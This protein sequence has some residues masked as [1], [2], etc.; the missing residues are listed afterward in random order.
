MTYTCTTCQATKQEDIP[1]TGHSFADT[2]ISNETHHWHSSTC[3][4]IDEIADKGEHVWDDGKITTPA[5]CS[6]AGV[7]TYTCTT[8]QA[9][10]QEDIPNTGH[11]FADTWTSNETHHW[12]SS[13]CEHTDEIADKGEHVWDDGKITTPASCSQAGVMTYTCTTCQAIKQEDIPNTG[14]PFADT[15]TSNETHHWHSSTCEHTEEITDKGEHVWDEGTIITSATFDSDG[16]IRY[17]CSVCGYYYDDSIPAEKHTFSNEWTNDATHHWHSATCEHTDLVSDKGEHTWDEGIVRSQPTCLTNG[18]ITYSCTVCDRKV[19]K[20][21]PATGHSYSDDWSTDSVYHW[22][23]ASCE[24]SNLIL[25]KNEHEWD[26]GKITIEAGC[27]TKGTIIF[28]C[29]TCGCERIEELLEK[30]HVFEDAWTS[31]NTYHWHSATCEHISEI[32]NKGEHTW[33]EGKVTLAPGC[34]SKGIFT[35]SCTVCGKTKAIDIDETGHEYSTNW[36]SDDDY[37]WHSSTCEH[38]D[39]I[40]DKSDHTWDEG[41]V[42][43]PPTCTTEGISTYTCTVCDK[44]KNTTINATG[45]TLSEKTVA[46]TCSSDGYVEVY[47]SVCD[48]SQITEVIYSTGHDCGDWSTTVASSCTQEGT[49]HRTC[50]DCD[51]EEFR[52]LAKTAHDYVVIDISIVDS[53][54]ETTYQCAVC[55]QQ[56]VQNADVSSVYNDIILD[57]ETDFYFDIVFDGTK[58]EIYSSLMIFDAYFEDTEYEFSSSAKVNYTITLVEGNVWRIAP[59]VNYEQGITYIARITND[60]IKFK[61]YLGDT[62]LFSIKSEIHEKIE[63]SND[64]IFLKEL[65]NQAPGYYPYALYYHEESE[66]LYLTVGKVDGLT[67]GSILCVGEIENIEGLFT[68]TTADVYFGKIEKISADSEGQYVVIMS[69]P[70]MSELFDE[71]DVYIEQNIDF[72]NSQLEGDIEEQ[73]EAAL[74][75]NSDFLG[76][77]SSVNLTAETYL[78]ERNLDTT[79]LTTASFMDC[80]NLDPSVRVDGTKIYVTINGDITIPVKTKSGIEIGSIKVYFKANT[81]IQ[82]EVSLNH[83]IKYKWFIPTGVEY[84]DFRLTQ[85]DTFTFEFGVDFTIDYNAEEMQTDYIYN[86]NSKMLHSAECRH[87]RNLIGQSNNLK[88]ITVDQLIEYLKQS[89]TQICDVCK[90]GTLNKEILMVNESSKKVHCFNCFMVT[91]NMV[92]TNQT[93]EALL[94]A[95]YTGCDICNPDSTDEQDFESRLLQTIEYADWSAK[96]QEITTWAKDSNVSEY[97]ATGVKLCGVNF[98]VAYVFTVNLDVSMV[99]QFKLEASLAYK[100]E[101]SHSNT[102][103]MRLQNGRVDTY[104]VKSQNTNTNELHVVGKAEFKYGIKADVYVS[105]IG[106]S[107][108]VR[109][110]MSAEAGVY[111]EIAGV[112]HIS[113]ID[114]DDYAAAYLEAGLYFEIDAYYKLFKWQGSTE[115]YSAKLALLAYGYDR[116]YYGYTDYIESVNI[117]DECNISSLVSLKANYY[118]LQTMDTA[119]EVLSLL[120]VDGKYNVELWLESGTYLEIV[121]GKLC[122]KNNHPCKFTDVLHI[123]VT[124]DNTWTKYVKGNAAYYLEDYVVTINYYNE[125]YHNF[126]M[127]SHTDPTCVL[128]GNTQYHCSVCDKEKIDV[129]SA[130]GVHPWDN[131]VVTQELTCTQDGY[132]LYSCTTCSLTR[133]ETKAATGHYYSG[134]YRFDKENHWHICDNCELESTITDKGSHTFDE[135]NIC[136][137]CGTTLAVTEG[138]KYTLIND[139]TAYEVSVGDAVDAKIVIPSEYEG[140]PVIAIAQEGFA[141]CTT[142]NAIVIPNTIKSVGYQAFMECENLVDIY[143]MGTVKD[144]CDIVFEKYTTDSYISTSFVTNP[145]AFAHNLYFGNKLAT[146]IVIPDSVTQLGATA[147]I[148][149][150][151]SSLNIIVIPESVTTIEHNALS[152]DKKD[153]VLLC[154]AESEPSGWDYWWNNYDIPVV[155]NYGGTH[156]VNND[157][158]WAT[159][160][161]N[162]VVIA[163][164]IGHNT[165]VRIPSTINSKKVVGIAE[166]AFYEI[167]SSEIFIVPNTIT[168]VGSNAFNSKHLVFA[169]AKSA[170]ENWHWSSNRIVWEYQNEHGTSDDGFFWAKSGQ[171]IVIIKYV[172]TDTNV[173]IPTTIANTSIS[174]I[175]SEAFKNCKDIESLYIPKTVTNIGVNAFSGCGALKELTLPFAGSQDGTIIYTVGYW[176]GKSSYSNSIEV[177]QFATY[178]VVNGNGGYSTAKYYLPKNLTKVTVLGGNIAFGAFENCINLETL[179]I[180]EDVKNI[181]NYAFSGC[182]NL[183]NIQYNAA[184]CADLNQNNYAFANIGENTDGVLISFGTNEIRIPAYLFTSY[185]YSSNTYYPNITELNI[186]HNITYIGDYAFANCVYVDTMYFNASKATYNTKSTVFRNLGAKTEGVDLIFGNKVTTVGGFFG[187]LSSGNRIVSITFEEG[188]VCT[189]IPSYAFSSMSGLQRVVLPN[190]I[191]SIE[192]NAFYMCSNLLSITLGTN[193]NNIADNAFDGCYKLVEICNYSNILLTK[194]SFE[195]GRIARSALDIYTNEATSRLKYDVEDYVFYDNGTEVYLLL[196]YGQAT[197]ITLPESYNGR[198]YDVFDYA[199][200]DSNVSSVVIPACVE[201]I[202]YSSF[203]SQLLS[204]VTLSEGLVEIGGRA[205][206]Y[207]RITEI[208]IPTTVT[209][210]GYEAFAG[211][212][213]ESI[214]VKAGNEIYHS[215]GN[216]IIETNTKTLIIGCKATIIPNDGSVTSIAPYAFSTCWGFNNDTL[217][218]PSTVTH[219]GYDAFFGASISNIV[220]E[221]PIGWHTEYIYSGMDSNYMDMSDPAKAANYLSNEY[222]FCDWYY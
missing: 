215:S 105:V 206:F 98:N 180:G 42:T 202:G 222:Y 167:S 138:L 177:K 24:H 183:S 154:N 46:S 61:N 161:S 160:S 21:I 129:I 197:E 121:N 13:T 119:Q 51:Y 6:Q 199:F 89:G 70:D 64:I 10:K 69:C 189:T 65:E 5:S 207:S 186:P 25:E 11:P 85:K 23:E 27:L 34:E 204:S 84:F 149:N 1:N 103:G 68:T 176:F 178:N 91:E 79:I 218:I 2:W 33:D 135:N 83:K 210:I 174:A 142:M 152:S 112:A 58:E 146:E 185:S 110:G 144:W 22:H 141:N 90:V 118:D 74:F 106:L 193:L 66:S 166:N 134:I 100:Y 203:S 81:E 41:I 55:E 132:W 29:I 168:Y 113:F 120:G 40:A 164:Y 150:A 124:G 128:Q 211:T 26:S 15:W 16:I 97:S 171:G 37:H 38:T 133:T 155:W 196:Y 162:Q 39:E 205:F 4:H 158:I 190:S 136:E 14:H 172:G 49:E 148:V 82:F 67:V 28:T 43:L 147:F 125:G 209:K 137:T 214:V 62:I 31:D 44:T 122:L 96:I 30:G 151:N 140:L 123:V 45:H 175:L 78:L 3:E 19:S 35:Y 8:C 188:S 86:T 60:N 107:K 131:G 173:V 157:F 115:I 139:G 101:V 184:T 7:M 179:I 48:Y 88:Y 143:F 18:V 156:G 182:V 116:A 72:S 126:V 59:T 75:S 127:S 108:Y 102:Y 198:K 17:T 36:T 130:T 54:E 50:N 169:M 53:T 213:L 76:Y 195:N 194:G 9:I 57:C 104:T 165:E 208:E 187:G 117:S 200:E 56:I 114:D 192:A 170:G 12:H 191:V 109:A 71:L 217:V 92:Y 212:Y 221:N 153:F 145:M 163:T 77:V 159:N 63:F 95:G 52:S 32:A 216:S 219:I 73:V 99:L 80:I 20:S 181:G 87:V 47:C 94:S 111:A 201:R 220:F 93:I